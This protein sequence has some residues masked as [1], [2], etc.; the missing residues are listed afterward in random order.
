[1]VA[2]RLLAGAVAEAPQSLAA[3]EDYLFSGQVQLPT[4]SYTFQLASAEDSAL[5]RALY[6][7]ASCQVSIAVSKALQLSSA[8]LGQSLLT[9][10][11]DH[12]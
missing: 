5:T 12:T 11:Q 1:M 6:E 10:C 3:Y 4:L 7:C 2:Q 8:F 9:M